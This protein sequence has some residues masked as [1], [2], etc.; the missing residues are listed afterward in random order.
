M[1]EGRSSND[2]SELS[3][4]E[5]ILRTF[6]SSPKNRE[7]ISRFFV[8]A[9]EHNLL[10]EDEFNIIQGAM[11]VTDIQVREVMIPRSKIIV[12][13]ASSTPEDFLPAVIK[14]GHSRFPVMGEDNDDVLGILHAKDLLPLILKND[15]NNFDISRYIRPVHKVPESKRLNKLLND[16]RTTHNHMALVIDEYGGIS[17]LIT[18]EDVLEEIVGEIEDEFDV[19]EDD[20]I[21]KLSNTDYLIKGHTTI[22]DFNN[23]FS[24]ELDESEF[25]TIAGFVAQEFGHLPQRN[26]SIDIN[27]FTFKVLHADKRRIHLLRLLIN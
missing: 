7:D 12:I 3:W 6:N 11:E 27:N 18:I 16:F 22:E 17:G 9:R 10:D 14:S 24:C 19:E 21:K 23:T 25:D 2:P 13:K 4:I 26:E 15:P 20:S 1:N 8:F 5:K